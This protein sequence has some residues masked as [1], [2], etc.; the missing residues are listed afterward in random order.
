MIRRLLPVPFVFLLLLSQASPCR[1]Q[2]VTR[3]PRDEEPLAAALRLAR[4]LESEPGKEGALLRLVQT[5]ERA[6]RLE[7]AVRAAGALDDGGAKARTLSR[8]ANRF[9]EAGKLGRAA[10]LLS[11]TLETARRADDAGLTAELLREI[12]GGEVR[13]NSEEYPPR[14]ET[15]EGALA[16]LFQAGRA[17]AAAAILTRVREAT[18]GTYFSDLSAA[19]VLAD[20]ARLAAPSDASEAA[21]L[22]SESLAAARREEGARERTAGLCAVSRAHADLGDKKT[23]EA[24]LDEAFQ[25]ALTVEDFYRDRELRDVA[26]VYAAQG[27]TDKA[28]KA[29]R[30]AGGEGFE[31]AAA[32]LRVAARSG[33]P[34]AFKGSLKRA[35]EALGTLDG[36]YNKKSELLPL[37]RE[38]GGRSPELLTEALGAARALED[39]QYRAELLVAVG[40]RYAETNRK[41]TALEVWQQALQAARA[42]ELERQDLQPGDSRINDGEKLQLLS[43]L[44]LRL[45]RAGEYAR[46]PEIAR[47]MRNVRAR[48]LSLAEGSPAGPKESDVKIAKVADELT[49][50]GQKEAA[51]AVLAAA[52]D[53]DE[54]VGEDV[55]HPAHADA[56]AAVGAAYA[57]AGDRGRA[58]AYFRRALQ[59][60]DED[61]ESGVDEKLA[62]LIAVGARY[63]EA[64]MAPDARA[65]RSLRRLVRGVESDKD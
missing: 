6:G 41:E 24:L 2:G 58:A 4:G 56:L 54:K 48:A 28:L 37:I 33:R 8:L 22:L 31:P 23:A 17:G 27:L 57:R 51:L 14:I 39:E 30:E 5:H 63:A 40:D 55:H 1:A 50:A 64:G 3:A 60:A 16:R 29:L 21:E 19:V 35:V 43:A 49:R 13:Y 18:R 59:L 12:V 10:E 46:V 42:V 7:E 61:R 11:E 20:A 34:E 36:E 38:Y 45:V 47:D 32:A 53:A 25:S 62:A 65:R 44:A 52:G 26:H 15:R 9:A